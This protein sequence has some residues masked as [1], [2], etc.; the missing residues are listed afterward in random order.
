MTTISEL[1]EQVKADNAGVKHD[2][3]KPTFRF[4]PWDALSA[5]N[6][7]L[8]FG[9]KKYAARNWERGMEWSRPWEACMRHL[10]AWHDREPSDPETGYSHLWHAGCCILFLIAFELRGIGVDDRLEVP[11]SSQ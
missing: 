7:V 2:T 6:K 10:W 5:I 11:P 8:I 4:L 9:A 3:G 1:A